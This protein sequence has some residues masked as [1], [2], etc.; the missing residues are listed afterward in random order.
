M[1]PLMDPSKNSEGNQAP[2]G[3][4]LGGPLRRAQRPLH[5]SLFRVPFG[6]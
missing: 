5:G 2:E 6:V 1:V 4:L 3:G